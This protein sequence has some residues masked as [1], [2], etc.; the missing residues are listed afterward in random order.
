[1]NELTTEHYRALLGLDAN[2]KVT[3]VEFLPKQKAVDIH[4]IFCG[5]GLKCPKCKCNCTQADLAPQRSWRH[6]DTMQFTTTIHASVPRTKCEKCGVL[7]IPV[8][9]ADKHSR[10]TLL[11]ECM[12]IEV[13]QACSSLASAA[14]LLSLNWKSVHAIMERAVERGLKLRKLDEVKHVG[15]D[16]KSFGKGQDY[17]SIMADIDNNRVLEVEPGRTREA[18]DNLWKTLDELVRQGVAAVAMDMWQPF[19]ESTR[20]ACP[21]AEVVHDKFHVSKY[22]G[23]AVDKVRRQENKALI[24]E[25]KD[26][27]KG[28]RQLWLYALENLPKDKSATFLSLQ[29]EDLQTGRAWSIKENFRHFWECK[30]IEDAEV[31]FRSWY[32]WSTHSK[33]AP[34]AKVANMLK[35]HLEGIL[36]YITHRITNATSEGF[37]SRIQSIKSAARGFR[38]FENYRTR[39]LFFCGRLELIPNVSNH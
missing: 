23:E 37:N 39:I 16:E 5:S 13:I 9:W 34:I 19:K 17:V 29:K 15:I 27:L 1:M 3:S 25:G 11:F 31:Y 28:T 22:L 20:V 14:T 32:S 2:W 21:N 18:V 30:T 12:A 26:T 36:A 4:I 33:L 6:L 10:F 35:R 8:P 24:E 7:T 38:N